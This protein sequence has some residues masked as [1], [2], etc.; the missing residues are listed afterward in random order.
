MAW[1]VSGEFI[2]TCSCNMLCPCWYGV[3]ELMIMDQGWCA[4]AMVVR[5]REG[6][7]DGVDLGGC[8]VVVGLH[9]PGPTLF[10]GD[11]TGRV[12]VDEGTTP[13]QQEALEAIFQGR[14]GGGMEVG[15]SLVARWL[16]TRRAPIAV[17]EDNGNVRATVDGLGEIV[18]KRLVNE[19]GDRM[20]MQNAAFILAFQLDDKRAELAPSDGSAWNDPD[21]PV[22][23]ACKS[24]AVGQISWTG[25]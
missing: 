1:N 15:A 22:P 25:A 4:T 16:P 10:D 23:F 20:S 11:G 9:F 18:S 13:E 5:I 6:S 14:R 7:L 24:G 19:A 12:Y 17:E 3:Q 21:M 2:E 8:D